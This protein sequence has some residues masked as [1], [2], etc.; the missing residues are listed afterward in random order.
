MYQFNA[1]LGL[2]QNV[3]RVSDQAIIPFNTTNR[4][5]VQFLSDWKSG[6]SVKNADGSD[7]PYSDDAVRALGLT[8][9]T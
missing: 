9:P 2:V 1:H 3:T 4:D 7:A 8:L 6:A 5:C